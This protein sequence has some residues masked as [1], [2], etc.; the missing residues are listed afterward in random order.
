MPNGTAPGGKRYT[1]ACFTAEHKN[2]PPSLM[3]RL[4]SLFQ[5]HK[6]DEAMSQSSGGFDYNSVCVWHLID[7]VKSI[8][9]DPQGK[10]YLLFQPSTSRR[11]SNAQAPAIGLRGIAQLLQAP[12]A[13][14]V[15][16][17]QVSMAVP[18]W[19]PDIHF[20]PEGK[21]SFD[22]HKRHNS[23]FCVLPEELQVSSFLW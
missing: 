3:P 14:Q 23:D 20:K 6:R 11:D 19:T 13:S 9:N 2:G 18:N 5:A 21:L 16:S 10:S 15:A 7:R 4:C 17:P 1:L 12:C 22:R 8:D